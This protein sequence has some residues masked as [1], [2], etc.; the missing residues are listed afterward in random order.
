MAVVF[1]NVA[2]RR[3]TEHDG[4]RRM[5]FAPA[6]SGTLQAQAECYLTQDEELVILLRPLRPRAHG[7]WTGVVESV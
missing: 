2:L 3:S 7:P 4:V 6:H 1:N 5:A